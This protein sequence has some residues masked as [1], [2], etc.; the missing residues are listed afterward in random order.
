MGMIWK[1]RAF[2]PNKTLLHLY[3][4]FVQ[5]LLLYGIV[6]WGPKLPAY[7]LNRLQLLQNNCIR[8]IVG[9]KKYERITSLF[10]KFEILKINDLCKFETAKLMFLYHTARLPSTFNHFFVKSSTVHNYYTRSNSLLKFYV[11][12]YRLARLQRSFKHFGVQIWNNIDLKTKLLSFNSFKRKI[13]NQ[14][15]ALY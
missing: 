10:R 3:Y 2:L 1:L 13:K 11:P 8:A 4:A 9:L 12:K 6:V 15:L 7:I 14:M 5:P